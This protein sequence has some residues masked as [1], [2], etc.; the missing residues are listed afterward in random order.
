METPI[1]DFVRRYAEEKTAR[2]HIPGHKGKPLLGMEP[3]DITEIDG[4][5][6]LSFAS[7]IIAES[8]ANA[9]ALFGCD[10]FYSAEGSSL[11]LR[12]MLSLALRET[13]EKGKRPKVAAARNLHKVFLDAAVLLDFDILFFHPKEEDSYHTCT[14]TPEEVRSLLDSDD[15]PCAVYLTA[16]DYLGHIPDIGGIAAVCHEKG[17]YLLVDGAHGGYLRFLPSSMH[18]ID[19]GADLCCSSAHKT[20]PVL[21][22]GAYLH[23]SPRLPMHFRE[24]A[25]E[26]LALFGSTSP[27]YLILQSLDLANRLLEDYPAR[28]AALLAR[29][30][31]LKERLTAHGYL[32]CGEDPLRLTFDAGRFGYTGEELATLLRREKLVPEFADPDFTVLM[33][34]PENSEDELSRLEDTLLAIPKRQAVLHRAPRYHALRQL[35]SPREAYFSERETVPVPLCAG[36]IL[37]SPAVRCPP[38][39]PI[40]A[41]GEEI[42]GEAIKRMLYYGVSSCTVVKKT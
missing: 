2:F 34:S 40:V 33:I 12:A 11:C 26:A 25:R 29:V 37:A 19:L 4:A 35:L 30:N 5:D 41:C 18:P 24:N 14:V 8:E 28:L 6:C 23:L 27:S 1:C 32:L 15:P 20:L 9:S 36:R 16:P 31:P 7:G 22:G 17:V 10:T 38:A 3:L 21:T 39:I 42:D 13:A